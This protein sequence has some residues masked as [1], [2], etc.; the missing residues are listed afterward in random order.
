M[1]QF[2]HKLKKNSSDT[3]R[4]FSVVMGGKESGLYV[5]STPSSAAKK[6]VTKLCSANKDKNIEFHIR[7][8]TQ[9]SKKKTY[10]PYIGYLEK[11]KEPIELMGR[12]INYKPFA[13]KKIKGG[14][15]RPRG[16]KENI[17]GVEVVTS[18]KNQS[19]NDWDKNMQN[20]FQK[21]EQKIRE[22]SK[23][24]IEHYEKLLKEPVE[25]KYN[26]Y[27]KDLKNSIS[28][29]LSKL[30]SDIEKKILDYRRSLLEE[31]NLLKINKFG[32]R[33][34]SKF[35]HPVGQDEGFV[36]G[37]PAP[38]SRNLE[39]SQQNYPEE[40]TEFFAFVVNKANSHNISKVSNTKYIIHYSNNHRAIWELKLS[41]DGKKLN[42]FET[43][44]YN[45]D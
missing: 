10:G 15:F 37:G 8:I 1:Q 24:L 9:N 11:L 26:K 23:P 5:S 14:M 17:K 16:D 34:N 39:H 12:V 7:E 45:S 18:K 3:K 4:H 38:N 13:N 21:M 20:R 29:R 35:S 31:K 41:E 42:K 25:N 30:H 2:G 40:F 27:N 19:N 32:T 6:A 43:H 44:E 22:E 28:Q 33:A 36:F